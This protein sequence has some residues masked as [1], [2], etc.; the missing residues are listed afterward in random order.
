VR[1]SCSWFRYLSD[2]PKT[3]SINRS[4]FSLSWNCLTSYVLSIL[5]YRPIASPSLTNSQRNPKYF[6]PLQWGVRAGGLFSQLTKNNH[7][8]D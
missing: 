3:Q 5:Y 4:S 6:Y 1:P 8:P 2:H 7:A